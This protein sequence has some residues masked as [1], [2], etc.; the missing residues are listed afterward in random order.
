[1]NT[2]L[3]FCVY[4][5]MM[6]GIYCLTFASKSLHLIYCSLKNLEK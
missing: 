4:K 3:S 6:K 2:L 5:A 1:M